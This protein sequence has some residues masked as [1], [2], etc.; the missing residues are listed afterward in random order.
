MCDGYRSLQQR[1]LIPYRFFNGFCAYRS[2]YLAEQL[3]RDIYNLVLDVYVYNVY[4][5]TSHPG[6]LR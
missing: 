3:P 1:V 4:I 5:L 6:R 2:T